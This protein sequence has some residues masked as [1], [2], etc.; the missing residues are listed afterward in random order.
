MDQG[1]IVFKRSTVTIEIGCV[2]RYYTSMHKSEKLSRAER[3]MLDFVTENM[4]IQNII[5]NNP[6]THVKFNKLAKKLG[7]T[8]YSKSTIHKCFSALAKETLIYQVKKTRGMYCVNPLY[9]FKGSEEEREIAIR[10]MLEEPYKKT[11][12]DDRHRKIKKKYS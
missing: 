3:V 7:I 10:T 1:V 9:Y 12:N 2:K 5:Y 4:D 8:P 11:I 6:T